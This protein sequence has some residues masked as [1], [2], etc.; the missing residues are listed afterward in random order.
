MPIW[1][2]AA[3]VVLL[4]HPGMAG[5]KAR[6]RRPRDGGIEDVQLLDGKTIA[7]QDIGITDFQDF[8]I[9]I[10]LDARLDYLV[11]A[12]LLLDRIVEHFGHTLYREG[13]PMY[14][15]LMTLTGLQRL[16]DSLKHHLR[17]S[18]DVSTKWTI[19]EPISHRLPLPRVLMKAMVALGILWGWHFF[20]GCLLLAFEGPGRIGEILKS[21]RR[22]LTLPQDMLHDPPDRA[23]LQIEKPK[24][25]YRGG[26]LVQHV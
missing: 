11:G 12:P 1:L 19:V 26:A 5:R 8:L 13:A 14:K 20:S 25:I 2:L 18:W 10:G 22:C 24:S 16:H 9:S 21:T 6:A 23:F 7:M 17:R 3:L 4:V 15:Y